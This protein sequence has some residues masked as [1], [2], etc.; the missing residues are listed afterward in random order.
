MASTARFTRI[1]PAG[2]DGV[3]D[4][5]R[6]ERWTQLVLLGP[7]GWVSDDVETWPGEWKASPRLFQLTGLAGGLAE[8]LQSLT[9]LTSLDLSLNA[10]GAEG[11]TAI[12]QS[13]TGLTSLDLG[14]NS[15]GAEGAKAIA[16]SLT[17]L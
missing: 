17:G 14:S 7:G 5:A 4:Q 3:L 8:K 16:Q 11:A 6:A 10:I 13:L 2:L 9:G 12:A 15:I 1:S